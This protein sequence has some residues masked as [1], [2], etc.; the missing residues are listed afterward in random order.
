MGMNHVRFT[1]WS[2]SFYYSTGF[3]PGYE[4]K[5]KGVYGA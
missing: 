3:I 4:R 1:P 5:T 2:K